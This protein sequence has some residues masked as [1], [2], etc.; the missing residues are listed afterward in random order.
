MPLF[1]SMHTAPETQQTP[2]PQHVA[3]FS[4]QMIAVS[5]PQS[6]GISLG[7]QAPLE[8]HVSLLS[9]QILPQQDW[10]WS[11]QLKTEQNVGQQ[12]PIK[13]TKQ[14]ARDVYCVAV[15]P[16]TAVA[17]HGGHQKNAKEA[18]TQPSQTTLQV[19]TQLSQPAET[20]AFMG[21]ICS[22]Y[23][24]RILPSLMCATFSIGDASIG[25]SRRVSCTRS[26]CAVD[27]GQARISVC[28]FCASALSA[29]R[30]CGS[31]FAAGAGRPSL[32]RTDCSEICARACSGSNGRSFTVPDTVPAR[33]LRDADRSSPA[34]GP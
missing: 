6:T 15:Q 4:Q 12:A 18:A 31:G 32:K 9:Q 28:A 10:L 5:S 34:P 16:S 11:Q 14:P 21:V 26:A 19:L 17:W 33:M 2:K 13:G 25:R 7:Q 30:S 24:R 1:W 29:A 3:P 22:E 8:L 20:S 27:F 23:A